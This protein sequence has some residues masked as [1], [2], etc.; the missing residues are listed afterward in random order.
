MMKLFAHI[1]F[2][3]KNDML[4]YLQLNITRE[5]LMLKFTY[6][7]P[8]PR[9]SFRTHC[10]IMVREVIEGRYYQPGVCQCDVVSAKQEL[11][12]TRCRSDNGCPVQKNR[13]P[14]YALV[15]LPNT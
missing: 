1:P 13:L 2:S 10:P 14:K 11:S 12:I 3:E 5:Y 8:L 15:L 4:H 7:T 6:V 9:L